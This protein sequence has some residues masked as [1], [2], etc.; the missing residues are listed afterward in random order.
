LAIYNP[1]VRGLVAIPAIDRFGTTRLERN[2]GLH[3]ATRADSGVHLTLRATAATIATAVATT[4]ATTGLLGSITARLALAW[5]LKPFGLIKLL[6][7]NA[8]GE[9]AT[10]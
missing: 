5:L 9:V 4:T 3:T 10:T 2:L 7:F 1:L 8:E 6:F